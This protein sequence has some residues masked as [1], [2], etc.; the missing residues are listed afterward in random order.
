[1]KKLFLLV[2]ALLFTIVTWGQSNGG[3]IK[4]TDAQRD[5]VLIQIQSA[6][7]YL[8]NSQLVGGAGRYKII[9][10]TNNYNSLKLD[11]ATG[12]VTALQIGIGDTAHRM[13]YLISDAVDQDEELIGRFELYPTK[14]VYNF[15]LLDTVYGLAY[16]VQWSTDES[17]CGRWLMW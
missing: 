4:L 1:M 7:S 2:S 10:T 14:N 11:T 13:E 6:T 17:E 16:Q 12:K 15:I 5:S 8:A 9:P 3:A